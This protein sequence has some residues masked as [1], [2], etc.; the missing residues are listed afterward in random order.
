MGNSHLIRLGNTGLQVSRLCLGTMTFGSSADEAE[1]V[2]IL[3]AATDAGVNFIDTANRYP[4]DASDERKGATE[5]IIGK[6]LKG[7]REHFILT[8]KA[9][10]PMGPMPWDAGTSRKHLLSAIDASLSRLG[11]D[12]VDL[13]Q[14]HRDDPATPLD[15]TLE[16]L[17]TIVRTGRARYVGVS[18]WGAWRIAR[19]L[20]RSEALRLVKPV[21]VQPRYNLL[22]RQFERDLFPMCGE[23]NLATLCYNPLAGGLL[24]GKYRDKAQPDASTRFGAGS[25]GAAYKQRYWHDRELHAVNRIMDVALRAGLAPERLAVAWVLAQLGVT[26]A[27][28]G[29]TRESQLPEVLR[30]VETKLDD[31][32]MQELDAITRAFRLGDA[33]PF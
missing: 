24:T 13:F 5:Q 23:E 17:D 32:V 7:R 8:T 11:T 18:N 15:E 21:T 2:S 22:F 10:G 25:T 33:P 20:G 4:S 29:A 27:V 14:L 26:C 1:S 12:Y 3:N 30:S 16:A 28:L 9:G 19:A 6:W 31:R